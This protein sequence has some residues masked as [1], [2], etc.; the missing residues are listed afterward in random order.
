M[1]DQITLLLVI[2]ILS[3][4]HEQ[5]HAQ[6]EVTR[7]TRLGD[8]RGIKTL[9]PGT[10]IKYVDQFRKIPY[11]VPPVGL[12]RFQKPRP[13]DNWEGT[14][15]ATEFG[16]SCIQGQ[17]GYFT[18]VPN[19][20]KAEDCLFLNIYV[21]SD[22]TSDEQLP[23][24]VWIH[25]GAFLYGQGMFYNASSL[26]SIGNV[27]VVTMNYR[28]GIFG[29][30]TL[31]DPI[32][33]GNYGLFDQ[34]LA[35]QWV[36][37]NIVSFNGNPDSVTIFGESAGGMSVSLL[38]LMPSNRGLFHRVIS[39]SGTSNSPC[40]MVENSYLL[41]K[42]VGSTAGC[43]LSP[44]ED[45][46]S[47]LNCMREIPAEILQEVLEKIY[48]SATEF[49]L[50]LG[51]GPVVDGELFPDQPTR[52]LSDA[53][54]NHHYFF[55]SLDLMTGFTSGE[56]S[57][58][59]DQ[60]SNPKFQSHFNYNVSAGLSKDVLCGLVAP[61]LV[62][63]YYDNNQDIGNLICD[64]Y[65]IHS[66]EDL[67]SQSRRTTDAHGDFFLTAPT[68]DIANI[69]SKE[70]GMSY[71]FVYMLSHINPVHIGPPQ[72]PWFTRSVHGDDLLYLFGLQHHNN[73]DIKDLELS[74]TMMS[75]WANFARFG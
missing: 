46:E 73:I 16:P 24:M 4:L 7:S 69:H 1:E 27:I 6:T 30:L 3:V 34:I 2:G 43:K 47:F 75:Y 5:I 72:P 14:L 44:N 40:L 15:D 23:V 55:R 13:L 59:Y 74:R 20:S 32:A 39:Q 66:S 62:R 21:P 29:F 56:G 64:E 28:L 22:V 68:I 19:K 45:K 57:L 26:A 8:I 9:V 52:L 65:S 60:L 10:K 53:Y 58:L 31:N 71:T 41:S 25:G 63:D 54:P 70:N 42:L 61:A 12:L 38:S 18:D 67:S 35:L 51:F 36:K 37:K 11:A 17:S 48:D 49:R 33:R 50:L